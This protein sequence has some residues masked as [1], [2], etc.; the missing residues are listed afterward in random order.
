MPGTKTWL[1]ILVLLISLGCDSK[2][3]GA[4]TV[5]ATAGDESLT[6]GDYLKAYREFLYFTG[7]PDNLMTRNVFLKSEVDRMVLTTFADTSG[8]SHQD[9]VLSSIASAV[10]QHKLNTFY[11]KELYETYTVPELSIR[12]A[13][14]RSKIEVHARHL[15]ARTE[16][17][18][19][20]LY[21][22]LKSGERFE[23]LA[24]EV[25]QDPLLAAN[26]GDLGYFS[27]N[28]MEPA[29]E[30]AAY[31]LQDGEIS[32]PVKTRNG[33]SIIQV[34][35]R[36]YEP[37]VT[38]MDFRVHQDDFELKERGRQ[39]KD[40]VR[41]YTASIADQMKLQITAEH[42]DLLF[43]HLNTVFQMGA[44]AV[45]SD[46]KLSRV[47][48][49]TSE[50]T[51]NFEDISRRLQKTR[52]IQRGQIKTSDDL[53]Q[54]LSG[55]VVREEIFQRIENTDWADSKD[56]LNELED[57]K[58]QRIIKLLVEQIYGTVEETDSVSA[59]EI[60]RSRYLSFIGDLKASSEIWTDDGLISSFKLEE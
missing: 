57:V 43:Q 42:L 22:R 21:S 48:L 6:F 29:F 39:M 51:W 33:Y 47:K 54:V 15:F 46:S 14:R 12:E 50:F 44:A 11:K 52:D 9:A 59:V 3:S 10:G 1:V 36:T 18:A 53:Y 45:E 16:E 35:D 8:F 27:Y 7:A 28:A 34:L 60:R 19:N 26:G 2:Q 20:T 32:R 31:G 23:D 38:E 24:A 41:N 37:L 56:F 49:R 5:I 55:L 13:F 40:V 30:D 4:E 17:T 58:Q 25:F